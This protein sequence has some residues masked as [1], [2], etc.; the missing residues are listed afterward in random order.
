MCSTSLCCLEITHN[1]DGET[2]RGMQ[3]CAQRQDA[4]SSH[5]LPRKGDQRIRDIAPDNMEILFNGGMT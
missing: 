1:G 3:H 2:D 5:K 4:S